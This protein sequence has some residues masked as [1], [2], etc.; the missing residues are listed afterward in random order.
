MKTNKKIAK[1]EIDPLNIL[2]L[3]N[4]KLEESIKELEELA[5]ALTRRVKTL[6]ETNMKAKNDNMFIVGEKVQ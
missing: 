1:P 5:I 2:L 3:H 6:E 4:L